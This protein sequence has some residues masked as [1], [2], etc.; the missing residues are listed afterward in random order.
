MPRALARAFPIAGALS[1]YRGDDLLQDVIAGSLLGLLTVPQA[2]AYAHLAGLPPQAGLYASLLPMV[3]YAL[4]G[5]SREM[6]VGPVA[7]IAL[8]VAA[9]V[10]EH[11]V[12]GSDDYA[13][14]SAVLTAEVGLA[15]LFL[16]AIRGS[17]I[18]NLLAEP[19]IN[20]FVNAAAILI[21][22]NQLDDVLGVEVRGEN[23]LAQLLSLI[24]ALPATSPVTASLGLLAVAVV[25]LFRLPALDRLLPRLGLHR[26]GPIAA[27]ALTSALVATLSLQAS[28][29][30][31][32]VGAVPAGLP[33][34]HL[35]TGSLQL[36]LALAPGA[37][38]IALIAYVES[39]SIG[40]NFAARRRRRIH[41][42]QETLALGIA[43]LAS[44]VSGGYAVAGSFA[45]SGINYAAGARTPI[46]ALVCAVVL[47]VTLMFFTGLFEPMPSAVLAV[48]IIISVAGLI[49]FR[50][51]REQ[52]RFSRRDAFIN[53]ATLFGVLLLGIEAGLIGGV[54]AA[55]GLLVHRVS[56]PHVAPLGRIGESEHFRNV[57][58]HPD[59]RTT[60]GVLAVRIDESIQFSNV[61][62]VEDFILREL[63]RHPD[64]RHLIIVCNAVNFIDSSGLA[65]IKRL[66][67]ELADLGIAVHLAEVKGPVMDRLS[68]SDLLNVLTGEVYFTTAEAVRALDPGAQVG[69][70]DPIGG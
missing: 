47:L 58:R 19:V 45:R 1:D 50:P 34:L 61:R 27:L 28:G 24:T 3:V 11:A 63:A 35:P 66:C 42:D 65:M 29:Q 21:V 6:I 51:L 49:D 44:S 25:L 10:S 46:S 60:P 17:G 57:N 12:P 37:A 2:L 54:L 56:R 32:V 5:S 38:I 67:E 53:A 55:L 52:W 8:L 48:I 23:L 69:D 31:R 64:A 36:W 20:G 68:R 22:I 9:T 43:N 15:L 18:V 14:V 41:P 40:A 62:F 70:P 30:V 59:A 7:I 16:F 4:M 33:A 13:R 26:L 39:Y